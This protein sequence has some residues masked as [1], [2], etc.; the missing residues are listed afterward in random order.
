MVMFWNVR[1]LNDPQEQKIL[2]NVLSSYN[3]CL[4]CLLE[5]HVRKDKQ[6]AIIKNIVPGQGLYKHL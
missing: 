6:F 4:I 1:G 2:K 3:G 5:T